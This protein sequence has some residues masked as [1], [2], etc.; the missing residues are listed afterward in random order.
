MRFARARNRF[1]SHV[2]PRHRAFAVGI[3][4]SRHLSSDLDLSSPLSYDVL[5]VLRVLRPSIIF[6]FRSL[7]LPQGD[8]NHYNNVCT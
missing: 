5:Q 2:H 6:F 3:R 8:V 1:P 4:K 7:D